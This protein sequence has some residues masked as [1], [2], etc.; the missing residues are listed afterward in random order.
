MAILPLPTARVSNLLRSNVAQQS[1]SRSQASL[2]QVQNELTTGRRL[3]APSDDAGAAAIAQQIRKVL[4][5]RLAYT[6]NLKAAGAQLAE[7]DTALG[8]IGNLL[9]EAQSIASANVGSDVT[10]DARKAAAA[11][12]DNLYGQ[13]LSLAN[14]SSMG[15]YLFAGERSTQPPF[16]EEGGGVKFVGSSA[17]LSNT[18]DDN[19]VLSF[20]VDGSAVFGALSTRVQGT[21]DLTPA[22]TSDTKLAALRGTGGTGIARGTIQLSDGTDTALVDL[23][24]AE[25]IGDVLDAINAAGLLTATVAA[26]GVSIQLVG[27]AGSD[28]SVTDVGGGSTAADLGIAATSAGA[29]LDGA[30]VRATVT[31]L[32]RLADLRAG[33]GLDLTGLRISNGLLSADLGLAGAVTVE[34]LLNKINGSGTAVRAQ[35]NAAGTGIDVLNPTQGTTMVIAE[36]GGA[37]ASQL[38][39]RSFHGGTQ[40][41]ELNLGRGVRTVAGADLRLT[42]SAGAAFDIDLDAASPQTVQG[43]ID[44]INATA[45]GITAGFAATGNGIVLTDTAGG[46]GTPGASNLNYSHAAEDLGLDGAAS[47]GVITGADVNAVEAGGVF[48][49]LIALRKALEDSDQQGIT[50]AA[51]GLKLDYDR[52]VR[53]RGETGARVREL[54]A[55]E[56][57]LGDLNVTTRAL[58]SELEDTDY[59]EAIARFS[60]LQVALQAGMQTTAKTLNLSLMDFLG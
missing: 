13:I 57:R 58:L 21:A 46:T 41:S 18:F 31:P 11:V 48:A 6:D 19:T 22:I 39:V 54:E 52:V 23:N 9:D 3:N 32:T 25:T 35:I 44:L 59:T 30:D 28:L 55:R 56:Q 14:K 15:M 33:A 29:T 43:V 38:G 47:G 26:D 37:T 34:D 17:T 2:L 24:G 51:E 5:Q 27:G 10:P 36:L 53:V 7:V 16:V 60:T 49:H 42:N 8:D 1:L 20:Q 4:E 50:E 45:T 40:L 12:I